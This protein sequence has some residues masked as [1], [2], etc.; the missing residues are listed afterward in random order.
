MKELADLAG[1]SV[2]ALHHYDA[3]GLLVPQKRSAKGYRLY[4]E[5]DVERLQQ[6]LIGRALGL[7]LES[8]RRSLDDPRFDR[9]AALT[10]Q[11]AELERSATRT[12]AMIRA[13]DVAL[14]ALTE[15]KATTM[16]D[17]AMFEG[18][19]DP[20]HDEAKE[21]W[22]ET[23]EYAEAA[24]RTRS[25]T[26]SDWAAHRAEQKAL[27][28]ALADGM[29]AQRPVDHPDVQ[30]LV[31]RHRESID[32]WFYPCDRAMQRRLADLY[33]SDARFAA[34]IDAFGEGLTRYLVAAIRA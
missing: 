32:R 23:S 16:D 29:R 20:H 19:E 18:F 5:G 30:E 14:A 8:I 4:G 22:G 27:Y 33:E 2:R 28:E 15:G 7:S 11:R 24:R 9:R 31:A 17:R 3:L 10:A 12:A 34:N 25:Y 1:I 6:I 21:R 26:E 13:I